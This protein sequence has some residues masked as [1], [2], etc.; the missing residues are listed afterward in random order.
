MRYGKSAGC[1][2]IDPAARR[3]PSMTLKKAQPGAPFGWNSE[4]EPYRG[5]QYSILNK[6]GELKFASISSRNGNPQFFWKRL[7]ELTAKVATSALETHGTPADLLA[8]ESMVCL[9]RDI[10]DASTVKA[11]RAV[12]V[13]LLGQAT[14]EQ[15]EAC[16][17]SAQPDAAGSSGVV[18]T[19]APAVKPEA[20]ESSSATGKKRKARMLLADEMKATAQAE[21]RGK[22]EIVD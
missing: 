9:V 3:K 5:T 19:D 17:G 18:K 20:S 22:G 1:H 12:F 10:F 8:G 14:V 15:F 21:K 6:N 7:S 16:S 11:V 4:G 2:E 13:R